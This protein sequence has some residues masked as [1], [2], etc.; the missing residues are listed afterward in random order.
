MN[1]LQV[2]GKK[3]FEALLAKANV[4]WILGVFKNQALIHN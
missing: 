3:V 4:L 2:F 1:R